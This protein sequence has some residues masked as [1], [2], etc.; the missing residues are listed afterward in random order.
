MSVPAVNYAVGT[1]V[2]P[3]CGT[4]QL[5]DACVEISV[6][7]TGESSASARLPSFSASLEQALGRARELAEER[8]DERITEQHLLL[9]LIGEPDAAAVMQACRVDSEALRRAVL[10]SLPDPDA[11]GAVSETRSSFALQS[12]IQRAVNHVQQAGRDRVTGA[13]VLFV[14]L[15]GDETALLQDHGM[16]RY[17]ATRF[18]SHGI[19]RGQDG[20]TDAGSAPLPDGKLT[21][22][23]L[24]NDDFTPVEFVVTVLEQV[25]DMDPDTAARTMLGIHSTG[26][27]TCGTYP[28]AVAAAKAAAVLAL[29]REDQHPLHCVLAPGR[30]PSA[31]S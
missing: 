30:Q 4:D 14:L 27:G 26:A 2:C 13:H 15:S 28:H 23:R 5:C 6:S 19:V 20:A 22:V 31:S 21:D 8:H 18:I 29:A 25:F 9:A 12:V 1:L 11:G 3:F 16:T 24:L 7:I 17:D 10:A